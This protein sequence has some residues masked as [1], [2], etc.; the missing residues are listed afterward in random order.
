MK[1]QRKTLAMIAMAVG[2]ATALSAAVAYFALGYVA[3]TFEL[4]AALQTGT[5]M[6]RWLAQDM[7]QLSELVHSHTL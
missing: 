5:Q 6:Q 1:L 3:R 2:A 4:Q 7:R